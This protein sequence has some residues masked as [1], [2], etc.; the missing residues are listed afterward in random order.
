MSSEI[1]NPEA[2]PLHGRRR[3]PKGVRNR[4]L[5]DLQSG[6]VSEGGTTGRV[7]KVSWENS[8]REATTPQPTEQGGEPSKTG[9]AVG[10]VGVL[11]SSNEPV[12]KQSTGEP[13]E[14]TWVNASQS[15]EGGDDGRGEEFALFNRITT[16]P[17][18]QKLQRT[19]YRK[20]KAEPKYRF[21]SLYGELLRPELLETAMSQVAH[22]DGVAG[23]DGE[24]CRVLVDDEQ[25]KGWKDRLLE[26]LRTRM[27]RPS[28]VRRVYIPKGDGKPRPLGIPTVKDR[29]VQAAVALVLLPI[30][31]ADSHP[32]S[33]AYRPRRG[34]HQAMKAITEA[35]VKGR[36]EVIDAD[37]SG[38]LDPYSYYTVVAEGWSKS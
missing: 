22:N 10:E 34:A 28:P 18:L 36:W 24:T 19:L 32:L 21:Y 37:L 27:Y 23:I 13:R 12:K 8:Q 11:R 17:K 38:Y 6:G 16:P 4:D 15:S 29:V 1:A 9:R 2:E 25:R 3:L 35:V 30:L 5:D 31:E 20:A 7:S 26:E 33:Y 14:G